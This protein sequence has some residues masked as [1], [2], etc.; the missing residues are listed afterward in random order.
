M[1]KIEIY[2]GSASAIKVGDMFIV[3]SHLYEVTDKAMNNTT[4]YITGMDNE[5][6]E[7]QFEFSHDTFFN[8]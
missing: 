3:K 1:T 2:T 7:R 6:L 5:G 4:V 8:Y